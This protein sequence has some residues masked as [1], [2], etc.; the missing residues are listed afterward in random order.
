[1][2]AIARRQRQTYAKSRLRMQHKSAV[3]DS[4]NRVVS[5]K[6][7]PESTEFDDPA[8]FLFTFPL[9]RAAR[10]SRSGAIRAE[11]HPVGWR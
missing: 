7:D 5:L 6:I 9:E 1:M 10:R 11:V 4:R 2:A 3:R 8:G